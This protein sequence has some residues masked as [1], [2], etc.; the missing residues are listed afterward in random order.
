MQQDE[1]FWYEK[2]SLTM[3]YRSRSEMYPEIDFGTKAFVFRFALE[4][5]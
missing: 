3:L 5:K 2:I 4:Q 1:R